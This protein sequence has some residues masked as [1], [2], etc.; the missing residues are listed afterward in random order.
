VPVRILESRSNVGQ[1]PVA[2][3]LVIEEYDSTVVVPPA[4]QARCDELGNVWVERAG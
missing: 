4:F 1:Q 3:P 2:G